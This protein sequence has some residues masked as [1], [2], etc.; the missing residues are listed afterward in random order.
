MARRV[1]IF[2][3]PLEDSESGDVYR[4]E[5][6]AAKQKDGLWEGWLEFVADHG[7]GT[8][9]TGRETTQ[10]KLDAVTYWATGLE[11]VYLEGALRRAALDIDRPA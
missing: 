9:R 10:S 6:W 2:S 4:V 7:S 11:P 5:A 1:H 8:L 3:A